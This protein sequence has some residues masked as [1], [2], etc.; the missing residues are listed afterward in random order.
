MVACLLAGALLLASC[1][2]GPSHTGGSGSGGRVG[3]YG[4]GTV[5]WAEPAGPGP[6]ITDIF[7]FMSLQQYSVSNAQQFQDLMYRPLYWFGSGSTPALNTALSLA[8]PPVYDATAKTVTITLKDWAWSDGQPL[9]AANVLLWMNLLKADATKWAFWVPGSGALPQDVVNVTAHGAH[10]VVF[11]LNRDYNPQ[12]FTDDELSQIT[13]LP[14][15]W[16]VTSAR[17]APGSGGCGAAPYSSVTTSLSSSFQLSDTSAAAKACAAVLTFLSGKTMA[18]DPGTYATNP[19]WKIVDGPFVLSAF[20][21]SSGRAVLVPNRAY[22]GAPRAQLPRLV[23]EPFTSVSGEESALRSGALDVGYVEADQ[24]PPLSGPAFSNG[25]AVAG[26][27]VSF[28]RD[29]RLAPLYEWGINY[30]AVNYT[31]TADGSAPI[32]KQL[33]VRQAMQ[34]LVDQPALVARFDGGYGVPTYGPVPSSPPSSFPGAGTT[35]PY[36]YDPSHAVSLLSSH[37][38]HVVP[39]GTSTCAYPGSAAGECG[40]GVPAGAKLSFT[41]VVATGAAGFAGQMKALASSFGQAGIH[42]RLVDKPYAGVVATAA[43]C[44]HGS[45]CGWDL[46]DWGGGW[47]YWPDVD[48]TGEDTFETGAGSNVG[49]FSDPTVDADVGLTLTSES[50]SAMSAYASEVG[51]QLPVLWQP[52]PAYSLTEVRSGLCGVFPQGPTLAL[53]PELWHRCP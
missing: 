23:E 51:S 13:P 33:Y 10:T 48:P 41:L 20:D 3:P 18:G 31:N 32:L 37:G 52:E 27:N 30:V 17:G 47:T 35:N 39:G 9:T 11:Q 29:D 34:S 8:E 22:S 6:A 42:L 4:G 50:A 12:W 21:A 53:T 15:A 43:P 14:S 45:R 16:D 7:P 19:L 49:A 44:Q 28:L 40:L 26:R 25:T 46:A 2:S 24:V 36:P 38:W 1:S 5:T